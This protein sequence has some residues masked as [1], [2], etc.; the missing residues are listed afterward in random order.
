MICIRFYHE[1]LQQPGTPGVVTGLAWTQAGGD[2][3]FIETMFTKGKGETLITGQLGDVMKESA[4]IAVS[5]VKFLFPDEEEQFEEKTI[6]TFMC[7]KGLCPR[8]A[9]R[10][11]LR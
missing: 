4:Q 11:A 3:L 8:T 7:R 5:L 1:K 6:C 9:P 10:P 2:I